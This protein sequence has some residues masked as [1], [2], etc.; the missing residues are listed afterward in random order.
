M[1]RYDASSNALFLSFFSFFF[2]FFSSFPSFL[3]TYNIKGN[4]FLSLLTLPSYLTPALR[5]F[6]L[7]FEKVNAM[8][9]ISTT[10]KNMHDGMFTET[11]SFTSNGSMIVVSNRLPFVL[12]RNELSGKLER[13]A[14]LV[15]VCTV[16]V[17][18]LIDLS[19]SPHFIRYAKQR[20]LHPY[21][22][23]MRSF[24]SLFFLFFSSLI[25]SNRFFPRHD[26]RNQRV[27]PHSS[28]S[29]DG[30]S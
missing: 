1:K 30:S 28:H 2:S 15:L 9:K 17:L 29:S 27:R 16:F 14:R 23:R 26:R 20:H 7:I 19:F 8:S 5:S 25:F 3:S 4:S 12:K 13:K 10:K 22:R 6:S 18:A 21:F 24:V 11:G